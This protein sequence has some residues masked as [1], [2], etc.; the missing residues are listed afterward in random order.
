[1]SV[2]REVVADAFIEISL[3][4]ALSEV[5]VTVSRLQVFH[6]QD[7]LQDQKLREKI[8][9]DFHRII[10]SKSILDLLQLSL[11]TVSLHLR[12]VNYFS[13]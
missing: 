9:F 11:K 5:E 2:L 6:S 3:D 10:N 4:D 8:P 1:M 7:W 12:I 13:W